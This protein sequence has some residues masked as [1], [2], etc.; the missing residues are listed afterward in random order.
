M[1]SSFFTEVLLTHQFSPGQTHPVLSTLPTRSKQPWPLHPVNLPLPTQVSFDGN[2]TLK[3][4]NKC[5]AAQGA[6]DRTVTNKTTKKKWCK[7]CQK[8][9]VEHCHAVFEDPKESLC[10][11]WNGCAIFLCLNTCCPK[12]QLPKR[13]KLQAEV[14][15][16]TINTQSTEVFKMVQS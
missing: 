3:L 11:T 6:I 13:R 12:L 1:K 8:E 9:C 10:V 5:A 2:D 7:R 14:T 16:K 15:A 4:I